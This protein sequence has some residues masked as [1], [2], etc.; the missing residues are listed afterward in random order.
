MNTEV[1]WR[2]QT[3]ADAKSFKYRVELV[4]ERDRFLLAVE[5]KGQDG[6]KAAGAEMI[7][8]G[9]PDA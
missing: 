4:H 9:F 2:P 5:L 8:S 7:P 1:R 3:G 6:R